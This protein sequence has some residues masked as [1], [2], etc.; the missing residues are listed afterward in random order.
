[1]RIMF[2]VEIL[3]KIRN[4][5][6][7]KDQI[8]QKIQMEMRKSIRLSKQGI[9]LIHKNKIREASMKICESFDIISKM[10]ELSRGNAE[11]SYMGIVDSAFQEYAEAKIFLNIVK[12]KRIVDFQ[13]IG[14]P[15][16]SYILGLADVIGELRRRAL[17]QIRKREC[18]EAVETVELM[19]ELYI[20]L[21][22]HDELM[23]LVQGLRRKLDV[24]R[25]L[26]EATRGD[27]TNE[28]RRNS[29]ENSISELR[30]I[31][32]EKTERQ[33]Q[34]DHDTKGKTK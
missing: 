3:E 26:I 1:M 6:A 27:T 19:E 22:N 7:E 12:S 11:L 20:E 8:R 5:L 10:D 32:D 33:C 31:L 25:H 30:M 14:V 28:L 24:A 18:D 4:D 15:P 2:L 17:E 9:F 29:L 13:E 16:S 23:I 21:V 34:T